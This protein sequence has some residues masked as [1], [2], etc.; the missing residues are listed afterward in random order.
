MLAY[1]K[2]WA[3]RCLFKTFNGDPDDVLADIIST[4]GQPPARWWNEW[5]T[6]KEFFEPDGSWIQNF[7]RIYDPVF[8]TLN[9]RI[10]DMGRG[11][12]PETC[13]R[14]VEGGEVCALEEVLR[15]MLT[16]EPS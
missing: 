2:F 5:R 1:M 14:N 9:Q 4:L 15:G 13:E 12:T 16:F 8:R 10:W 11:M 6:R 7:K 3:K